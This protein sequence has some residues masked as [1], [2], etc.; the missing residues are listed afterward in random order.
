M[1]GRTWSGLVGGRRRAEGCQPASPLLGQ[2]GLG[3]NGDSV[4]AG[5][6][7]SR[8]QTAWGRTRLIRKKAASLL[9]PSL[10]CLIADTFLFPW[11][12]ILLIFRMQDVWYIK[13]G[14]HK[15]TKQ[16]KKTHNPVQWPCTKCYLCVAQNVL[17]SWSVFIHLFGISYGILIIL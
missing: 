5:W 4:W 15:K 7:S 6:N 14:G 1:K 13:R 17:L 3:G 11:W 10:L 2:R 16:N 9:A 8:H 12:T